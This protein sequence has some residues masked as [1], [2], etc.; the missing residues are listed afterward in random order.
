[1]HVIPVDGPEVASQRRFRERLSADV[2]LRDAYVARKREIVSRGITN[3][4]DYSLAKD[5]FIRGVLE[6]PGTPAGQSEA[7]LSASRPDSEHGGRH[8]DQADEHHGR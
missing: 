1:M 8:E 6:G 5:D 7:R 4:G 3:A 2:S